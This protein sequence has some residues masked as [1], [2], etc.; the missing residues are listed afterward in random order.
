MIPPFS[1]KN[2]K[3]CIDHLITNCP[4]NISN[5]RTYIQNNNNNYCNTNA[6]IINNSNTILSDHAIL[7]CI[8][9]NKDIP[10]PKQFK[11]IRNHNLRTKNN[12]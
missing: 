1:A 2:I 8:Y 4:L 7:S 5:V 12:I 6:N 11:I 9:N 10:I 3:S